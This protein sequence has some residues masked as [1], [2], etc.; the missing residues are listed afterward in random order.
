MTPRNW[1]HAAMVLLGAA[2]AGTASAAPVDSE[3]LHLLVERA[4]NQV[5]LTVQGHA[6]TAGVVSYELDVDGASTVRQR[7]RATLTP[8]GHQAFA[9]V[10]IDEAKPWRAVLRV[11]AGGRHYEQV[12]EHSGTRP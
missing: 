4:D 10:T 5:T 3:P 7:G 12:E 9:R 6:E 1:V 8:G 11:D 2:G